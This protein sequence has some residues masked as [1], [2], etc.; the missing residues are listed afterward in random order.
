MYKK[1]FVLVVFLV[2][3][4]GCQNQKES[5]KENILNNN[6]LKN[7]NGEG[8]KEEKII[9]N[10]VNIE[11]IGDY[12]FAR[13]SGSMATDCYFTKGIISEGKYKDQELIVYNKYRI[14]GRLPQKGELAQAI[15][16]PSIDELKENYN[17]IN[18]VDFPEFCLFD[19]DYDKTI[20]N[21]FLNQNIFG[22][23]YYKDDMDISMYKEIELE[24]KKGSNFIYKVEKPLNY[25]LPENI[26]EEQINYQEEFSR[27]GDIYFVLFYRNSKRDKVSSKETDS[28][29]VLVM[30]KNE[31]QFK[32]WFKIDTHNQES[33]INNPRSLSRK[34]NRFY[35]SIIDDSRGEDKK[36]LIKRIYSDDFGKSWKL[37]G[38]FYPADQECI[39]EQEEKRRRGEQVSDNK[40]CGYL[41]FKLNQKTG[42]YEAVKI[43][44]DG[45]QEIVIEKHC[46]DIKL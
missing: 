16:S 6:I 29:G 26:Y 44:S 33:F 30:K 13:D 27:L 34:E 10:I 42:N 21:E 45:H 23:L 20:K 1:I 38:C 2:L 17:K 19:E 4:L 12:K 46:E 32:V 14:Q 25:K 7:M 37:A 8:G 15:I 18:K 9:Q 24:L 35:L 43:Y 28:S 39:I 3:M 5:E 31:K 40:N 41:S 36:G 22:F 11:V